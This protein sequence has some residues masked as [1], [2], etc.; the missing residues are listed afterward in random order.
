MMSQQ[1][2]DRKENKHLNKIHLGVIA[3]DSGHL[4]VGDPGYILPGSKLSHG[5][6]YDQIQSGSNQLEFKPDVPGLAIVAESGYGDG[7]Y[8]VTALVDEDGYIHKIIIDFID[9]DKP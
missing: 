7:M 6:H 9:S 1:I 3:I 4:I 8:P 5:L 2:K